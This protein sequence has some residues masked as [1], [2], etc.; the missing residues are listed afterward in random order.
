MYKL[1]RLADR[2]PQC[3]KRH[4]IAV[5]GLEL[6]QARLGERHLAGEHVELR[7]RARTVADVGHPQSFLGLLDRFCGAWRSSQASTSEE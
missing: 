5:G 1:I 3:G 6:V 2:L 7:G 4:V